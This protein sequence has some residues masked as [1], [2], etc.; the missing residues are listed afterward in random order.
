MVLPLTIICAKN[1]VDIM[2]YD[3]FERNAF[4][5]PVCVILNGFGNEFKDGILIC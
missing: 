1:R 4:L 2:N 5:L 3:E